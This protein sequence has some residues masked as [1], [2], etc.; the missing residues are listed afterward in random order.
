MN[1]GFEDEA[2]GVYQVE[3]LTVLCPSYLRGIPI[4]YAHCGRFDRLRIDHASTTGLRIAFQANP[5]AF[6]NSP[7]ILSQVP[8]LCAI[9]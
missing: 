7:L 9:V 8:S 3:R 5:Q 4:L 6:A 1:L 2:F